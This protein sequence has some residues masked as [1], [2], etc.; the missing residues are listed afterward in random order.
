MLYEV[1]TGV[2]DSGFGGLNILKSI[3]KKNSDYDFLYLGDT[4]RVPYGTRSQG[5]VYEFTKQ[6]V[7]FLFNQNCKLIILA[8]NTASAEALKKI[9]QEYVIT[10]YSI[11]YTKLYDQSINIFLHQRF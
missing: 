6:A 3:L 9:Q 8:C 7:D 5:V 1:I 2:F 11:H 4:A 10:S